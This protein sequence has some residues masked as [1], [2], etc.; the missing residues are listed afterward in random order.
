MKV[1]FSYDDNNAIT[2]YSLQE[3]FTS[4]DNIVELEMTEEEFKNIQN[5]PPIFLKYDNVNNKVI[6][7]SSFEDDFKLKKMEELAVKEEE[8]TNESNELNEILNRSVEYQNAIAEN[9]LL[10]ERLAT[11]E[12][13]LKMLFQY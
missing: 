3:N 1:L 7:E 4:S 2:G 13:L 9:K 6:Y 11:V 8:K 12:E 10:K 5:Y